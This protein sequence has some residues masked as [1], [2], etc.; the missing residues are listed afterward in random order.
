MII[1]ISDENVCIMNIIVI[2]LYKVTDKNN[3]ENL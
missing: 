1:S 2:N 3:K